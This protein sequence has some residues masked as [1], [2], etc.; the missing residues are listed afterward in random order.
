MMLNIYYPIPYNG[1]SIKNEGKIQKIDGIYWHKIK[2]GDIE[3]WIQR[4]YLLP[5]LDLTPTLNS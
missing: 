2:W 1:R 4:K 3:G 5:N